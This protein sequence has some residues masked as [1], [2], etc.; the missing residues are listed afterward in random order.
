[1]VGG[2]DAEVAGDLGFGDADGF[3]ELR[4]GDGNRR[5]GSGQ[6]REMVRSAGSVATPAVEDG[7]DEF[8][9]RRCRVRR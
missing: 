6:S 3:A 2:A 1:V 9:A 7:E 5:R 8:V 4:G